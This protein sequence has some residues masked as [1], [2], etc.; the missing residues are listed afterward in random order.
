MRTE[1]DRR[2]FLEVMAGAAYLGAGFPKTIYSLPGTPK[3]DVTLRI[4]HVEIEIAP[5][6]IVKTTG[7]NGSGPGPVLRLQEG[8]PVTIDVY[9]DTDDPELVHWHGLS[10]SSS[11]DGAGEEGT[12]F[13]P[14]HGS[15][16]YSFVPRPHGNRWYH[17]HAHAGM[18]LKRG[19]YSGQFGNLYVEPRSEPGRYDAEVFLALHGWNAAFSTDAGENDVDDGPEITYSRFSMNSHSLGFGEPVRVTEG[20]KVIFRILNASATRS[21]RL[22]F[23]GHRFTIVALDGNP[24]PVQQTVDVVEL[25]PAERVDAVVT[26]NQ[27]GVWTLGETDSQ[28]RNSGMGIVVEYANR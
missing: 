25:G 5:G 13:V 18:E 14:P 28:M 9:N 16:R 8:K 10:I 24:V 23:P 4:S 6:Q 3:P 27:P 19:N 12:P 11:V 22:S 20:Q 2:K 7:Y 26:M 1:I 15:R 21:H 17:T